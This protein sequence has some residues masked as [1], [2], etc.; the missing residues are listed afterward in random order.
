MRR[1]G[2]RGRRRRRHLPRDP[3]ESLKQRIQR[4]A[5]RDVVHHPRRLEAD[6]ARAHDQRLVIHLHGAEHHPGGAD[7]LRDADN[8]GLRERSSRRHL[9]PFE[10]LLPFQPRDRIRTGAAETVGEQDRR[11]FADPDE[12]R[13][14]LGILERHDQDSI[15]RGGVGA[16][17]EPEGEKQGGHDSRRSGPSPFTMAT[18]SRQV[19]LPVPRHDTTSARAS[20]L[21]SVSRR[22]TAAA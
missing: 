1:A 19:G 6:H 16:D 20:R 4:P 17:G 2:G 18:F 9:Q 14:A 12:T 8:R 22:V 11:R 7:D 10:R 15:R 13:V 5:L 3:V 21:N